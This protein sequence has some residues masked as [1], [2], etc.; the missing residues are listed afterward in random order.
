MNH[1]QKI[2]EAIQFIQKNA[3]SQP[4]LDEVAKSVNLSPFHFQRLFTEWAGVSPKQFLQYVTLQNA[5]SILSKPQ[6]TLFD[7]AFETGLSGTSR[8]HDLF[9]KIEG[10]TP[11]EFKNGGEN[12]RIRYSFQKSVFGSYLIASTE[13]GICNLFFYD[14]PEKQIVSELKEQWDRAD[15]I[16]QTDENQNRVIRF[17]DKTLNGNEK[18]KLH[19]KG[20]EF[21]IKVW[22]A[23]LKIPE[24]QLSSYSDIANWIGQESASRA[25]GTAIGKNPIGYLIPC[26]RVIKSTG[27]IGEYRWGSERKMAMIGWEASKV[28]I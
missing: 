11:G 25:V 19:L 18:I 16:E 2:A 24:G 20:T 7:A 14:I 1:Y 6:N 3:T 9:V 15:I 28:K 8:L 27:G 26:H 5:K 21:Q 17:F 13:K 23:L 4:E 22:E 10:M 12:L